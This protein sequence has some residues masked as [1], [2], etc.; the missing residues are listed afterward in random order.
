[1]GYIVIFFEVLGNGSPECP[2]SLYILG[3]IYSICNYLKHCKNINTFRYSAAIVEL[4]FSVI[5]KLLAL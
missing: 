1:M 2:F 3:N 5:F 4:D